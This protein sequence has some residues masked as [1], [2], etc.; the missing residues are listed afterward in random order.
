MNH[1]VIRPAQVRAAPDLTGLG[2]DAAIIAS[3][4]TFTHETLDALDATLIQRGQPRMSEM[5]ELAN[6]SAMIGNVF[7]SGVERAS[8]GGF[9]SN[10]PHTYPDL[11]GVGDGCVS[12]EIKVALETNQPK[13]HLVKPGPHLIVRYVLGGTDGAFD[14]DARGDVVW[15]WEVRVGMLLATH[16]NSSNTAGDSGKT[17]VINA[18]GMAAL[19]PVHFDVE[20]CPYGERSKHRR[21]LIALFP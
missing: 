17:A 16:F 21:G 19:A 12:V 14:R 20:R 15:I 9:Q 5:I 18:A 11:L 13:G 8:N 10:A 4:I 7:R 3:A 2:L 1:R 6:L